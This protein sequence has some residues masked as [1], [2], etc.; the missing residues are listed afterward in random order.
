MNMTSLLEDDPEQRL[1]TEFVAYVTDVLT[2]TGGATSGGGDGQAAGGGGYGKKGGKPIK[3]TQKHLT[4]E[5][6][7]F[8]KEGLANKKQAVTNISIPEILRNQLRKDL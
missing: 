1:K 8:L 3:I 4:D 2:K 7:Q 5:I 6:T